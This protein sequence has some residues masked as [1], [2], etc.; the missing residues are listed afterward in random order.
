MENKS[1]L[2]ENEKDIQE[3]TDFVFSHFK[4]L[5]LDIFFLFNRSE[6]ENEN[7]QK[8]KE[9]FNKVFFD[10]LEL[11]RIH[12]D[13]D[14]NE[15]HLFEYYLMIEHLFFLYLSG[16]ELE[17]KREKETET[18]KETK[19]KTETETKEI[20]E[21]LKFHPF[22]GDSASTKEKTP[23]KTTEE[24]TKQIEYL[25]SL[26]QPV[27]RTT[28]WYNYRYNLITASNA[29]KAFESQ[30]CQ[31]QLIYEKCKPNV[32]G[33][34]SP[35]PIPAEDDNEEGDTKDSS[36]SLSSTRTIPISTV[37]STLAQQQQPPQ[38]QTKQVN[39]NSTLHWGQKY[40]P[41]SVMIYEDLYNTK[42]QDFG[43]IKHSVYSF[44]GASPDGINVDMSNMEKYGK[45]LEIKNIVNREITG[46]PKK[47]YAVQ[48]QLQMEVCDLD[49]C[50]FLETKFKESDSLEEL[51]I[52]ESTMKTVQ[53]MAI[54]QYYGV[55]MY[56]ANTS[57]NPKYEYKIFKG[58][59]SDPV[60]LGTGVGDRGALISSR[61]QR[62]G[63]E[64][65]KGYC[66]ATLMDGE[67]KEEKEEKSQKKIDEWT[68]RMMEKYDELN[69]TNQGY[70]YTWIKNIYWKV[71][72]F[73][74]VLVKR[75]REW[76]KKSVPQLQH[77]WNIIEKERVDGYEHRAPKKRVIAGAGTSSTSG[78]STKWGG[79]TSANSY[80]FDDKCYISIKKTG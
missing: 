28:E 11:H 42:I 72:I 65:V 17:S 77:I 74:C 78:K 51:N 22:F 79:G 57:G 69:N 13:E 49:E 33:S 39:V 31:N 48:M 38:S 4:D 66:P 6:N 12:F 63:A 34:G 64:E 19:T 61:G 45:M 44:L 26:P 68:N 7:T 10:L 24:I 9:I 46:I 15:Q 70:L 41:L 50:D 20:N 62:S 36:L 8:T 3:F 30:A 80:K 52:T 16:V 1:Y 25:S 47:E 43:C 29:Y 2:F 56:F 27:Q 21:Y 73:S 40:E 18:E 35:D 76:F 53:K 55:I 67:K 59:S 23:S 71:D 54:P 75:D 60:H 32:A 14:E 58:F 37:A 5:E